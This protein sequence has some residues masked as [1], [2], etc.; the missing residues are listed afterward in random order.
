MVIQNYWLFLAVNND[1]MTTMIIYEGSNEK[2]VYSSDI[3]CG[4]ISSKNVQYL[5]W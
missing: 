2:L 4:N 5:F 3:L 1:C